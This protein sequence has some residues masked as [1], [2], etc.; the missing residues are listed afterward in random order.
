MGHG[1]LPGSSMLVDKCV[2]HSLLGWDAK[3]PTLQLVAASTTLSHF[4]GGD[5][6]AL[7]DCVITC[8]TMQD[9]PVSCSVDLALRVKICPHC[10]F[11]PLD[12]NPGR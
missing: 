9:R 6:W 1:L 11:L 10:G 8:P 3:P 7:A 12:P 4:D 5:T 2:L